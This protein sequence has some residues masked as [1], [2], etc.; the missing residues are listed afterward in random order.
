MA[1]LEEEQ[2]VRTAFFA[3]TERCRRLLDALFFRDHPGSYAD[4]AA[5]LGVPVGS[6]GPTRRRCLE[7]LKRALSRQGF[8]APSDDDVSA[9]SGRS[10]RGVKKRKRP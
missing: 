1:A 6:L 3:L 10:S 8:P 7:A 4:I 5:D 2:A 9:A